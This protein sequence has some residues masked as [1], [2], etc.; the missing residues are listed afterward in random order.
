M[1]QRRIQKLFKFNSGC[2]GDPDEENPVEMSK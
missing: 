2:G 1:N